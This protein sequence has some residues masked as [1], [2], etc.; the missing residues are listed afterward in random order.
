MCHEE[1]KKG[2]LNKVNFDEVDKDFSS[3]LL[4]AEWAKVIPSWSPEMKRLQTSLLGA[5]KLK[6]L[7]R[8]RLQ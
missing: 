8:K 5:E 6:R 3:A 4:K 7:L 1:Q 2:E